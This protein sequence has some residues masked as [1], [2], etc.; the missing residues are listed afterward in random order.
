MR[1]V[2]MLALLLHSFGGLASPAAVYAQAMGACFSGP[3][4][5]PCCCCEPVDS[6]CC[7]TPAPMESC[8]CDMSPGEPERLPDAPLPRDSSETAPFF[9]SSATAMVVD[10]PDPARHAF[11]PKAE[12]R[13]HLS[14]NQVQALLCVWRT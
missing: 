8:L 9:A 13:V 3:Q 14:H 6:D 10:L 7:D 4:S 5:E 11:S 2:L 1:I 12:P